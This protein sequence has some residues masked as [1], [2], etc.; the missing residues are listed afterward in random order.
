MIVRKGPSVRSRETIIQGL[1]TRAFAKSQEEGERME[2]LIEWRLAACR[3]ANRVVLQEFSSNY[4]LKQFS[5]IGTTGSRGLD[6]F[7]WLS[8]IEGRD[9]TLTDEVFEKRIAEMERMHYVSRF[10][11]NS[12]IKV[13]LE[14]L[15]KSSK[16]SDPDAPII[17]DVPQTLPNLRSSYDAVHV[18]SNEQPA[19]MTHTLDEID[20]WVNDYNDPAVER[21]VFGDVELPRLFEH[22]NEPKTAS[23]TKKPGEN[24]MAFLQIPKPKYGMN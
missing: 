22:A 20:A 23:R 2:L 13:D 7:S 21:I 14:A 11:K 15:V 24:Q 9:D 4:K 18:K 1:L 17:V 19:F 8:V 12:K 5:E 16:N 3:H 6:A 10:F